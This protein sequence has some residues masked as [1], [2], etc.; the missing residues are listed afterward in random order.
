M[1]Y[2]WRR[3]VRPPTANSSSARHGPLIST[4]EPPDRASARAAPRPRRLAWPHVA[5]SHAPV[6]VE[7]RQTRALACQPSPLWATRVG[8]AHPRALVLSSR[9]RCNPMAPSENREIGRVRTGPAAA[10]CSC[11]ASPQGPRWIRQPARPPLRARPAP[12]E[13]D[14]PARN[15]CHAKTLIRGGLR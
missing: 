3:H 2:L 5:Q 12:P 6:C 9:N 4:P 11:T 10:A 8:L 15:R 1:C 13:L 14:P 7:S